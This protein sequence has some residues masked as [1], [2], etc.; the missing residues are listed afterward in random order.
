MSFEEFDGYRGNQTQRKRGMTVSR[1]TLAAGVP[2]RI[3]IDGDYI[4]ILTAS[5][6][7]LHV[8]FDSGEAVPMYEGVGFRRYYGTVEFESATGQAVVALL[9]FGSVQ[10]SRASANVNVTANVSPGNTLDV[11]GDVATV[12][13]A[14]TL[15]SA[16]DVDRLYCLVSNPSTNAVSL[17]IGPAAVG[18]ASGI[19]LEPGCSLPIATTA[20]VYGF[21]ASGGA[22]T[23]SVGNVRQV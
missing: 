11:G 3:A 13:G 23:V 14:A 6:D 22:V 18:A 4:H 8:R 16:A 9:G 1:F 21:Q 12:S 19:L 5:V 10:D 7:D 2:Q 20:A 15:L 17:R